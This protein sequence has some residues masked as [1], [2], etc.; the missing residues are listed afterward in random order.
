MPADAVTFLWG[1]I[2][3]PHSFPKAKALR[4]R[5]PHHRVVLLVDIGLDRI[6]LG[7]LL[8]EGARAM[9]TPRKRCHREPR[10]DT[11]QRVSSSSPR[12]YFFATQPQLFP[13]VQESL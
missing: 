3:V 13:Q 9:D 4:H 8:G 12:I 7:F 6:S 10:R 11:P 5:P 1:T 2:A